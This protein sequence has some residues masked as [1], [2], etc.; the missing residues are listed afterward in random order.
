MRLWPLL[1]LVITSA[2]GPAGAADREYQ[3]ALAPGYTVL[4]RGESY[5]QS[6]GVALLSAYGLT[7]WLSAEGQVQCDRF[8]GVLEPLPNPAKTGPQGE[9]YDATRCSFV[10]TLA[11]HVGGLNV[12]TLALG[13]GYRFEKRSQQSVVGIVPGGATRLL[14][15]KGDETLHAGVLRSSL[16]FE[17]RLLEHYGIGARMGLTIP[18]GDVAAWDVSLSAV[19]S[20]YS[21]L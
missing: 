15:S 20:L 17:R 4:N 16:G 2:A 19:L 7:D 12:T 13:L 1:L 5:S 8:S 9:R 14:E 10:P 21:F 18:L 6:A 11:V 3:L